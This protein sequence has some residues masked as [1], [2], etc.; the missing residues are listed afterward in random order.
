LN[1]ETRTGQKKDRTK[2][3]QYT[4]GKDRT[5]RTDMYEILTAYPFL[6]FFFPESGGILKVT[7]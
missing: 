7:V 1:R 2:E 5:F 3:G 4:V 6:Y